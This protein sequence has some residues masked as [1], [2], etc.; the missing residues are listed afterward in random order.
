MH[1]R[2][3]AVIWAM[4]LI[5][6]VAP[7]GGWEGFGW[8]LFCA[9]FQ[10]LLSLCPI[11]LANPAFWLGSYYLWK[12]EAKKAA[13]AGGVSVGLGLSF[14]FFTGVPAPPW[15]GLISILLPY[16]IWLAS[17]LLFTLFAWDVASREDGPKL[18]CAEARPQSP[19]TLGENRIGSEQA[20]SS[21][22][23]RP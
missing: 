2:W 6:F 5:S 14:W 17:L 9:S 1:K 23:P 3:L 4:Y 20:F 18:Q 16:W 11:W 12:G 8:Q 21:G 10:F 13:T 7:T 22:P 15:G 19:A